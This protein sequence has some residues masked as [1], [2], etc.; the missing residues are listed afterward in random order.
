MALRED[1]DVAQAMGVDL[2]KTKLLAFGAGAALVLK[3]SGWA[4]RR[5]A[6]FKR[7]HPMKDAWADWSLRRAL[8][9]LHHPAPEV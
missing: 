9:F 7:R 3:Y 5:Y 4:K 1:E 6:R 2:V 8:Q